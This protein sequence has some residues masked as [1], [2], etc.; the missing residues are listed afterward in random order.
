M[1]KEFSRNW[2]KHQARQLPNWMHQHITVG[3]LID[4][5]EEVAEGRMELTQVGRELN[6]RV[7]INEGLAAVRDI[8]QGRW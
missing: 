1:N 2:V 4:I 3:D 8:C 7:S 6:N 5:S